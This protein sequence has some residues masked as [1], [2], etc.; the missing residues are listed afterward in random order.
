MCG[1]SLV[2]TSGGLLSGCGAQASHCR[3]FS[4]SGA[5]AL[6]CAGSVV[7]ARRLSYPE[8]GGIFLDQ[9][10]NLCPCIGR[11]IPNCWTTR[12]VPGNTVKGLE[13]SSGA[14]TEPRG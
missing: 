5:W 8:A 7:V 12:E 6:G 11:W 13:T 9:G 10:S 2:E 14:R 4:W 3:G 1:L